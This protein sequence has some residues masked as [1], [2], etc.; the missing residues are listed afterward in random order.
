MDAVTRWLLAAHLAS[1]PNAAVEGLR[2]CTGSV[3]LPVT[4]KG[5]V[6]RTSG[7]AIKVTIPMMWKQ[8]MNAKK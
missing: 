1:R 4:W 6:A 7:A 5:L 2:Q 3:F 8:S